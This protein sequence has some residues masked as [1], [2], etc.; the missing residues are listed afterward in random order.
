M[1]KIE[2]AKAHLKREEP[3]TKVIFSKLGKYKAN[4][5]RWI[6]LIICADAS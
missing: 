1:N 5:Q 3:C 4:Y 2:L 6:Y